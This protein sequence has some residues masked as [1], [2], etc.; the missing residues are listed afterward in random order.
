[1]HSQHN[2]SNYFTHALIIFKIT[3]LFRLLRQNSE[4]TLVLISFMFWYIAGAKLRVA[5]YLRATLFEVFLA[6]TLQQSSTATSCHA[7]C[8]QKKITLQE[9][10]V[11][12]NKFTCFAPVVCK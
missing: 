5:I 2:I 7:T 8:F 11:Y 9:K 3:Y 12:I 6:S 4:N 10:N 1:M